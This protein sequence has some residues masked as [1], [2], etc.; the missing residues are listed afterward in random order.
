M[1]EILKNTSLFRDF[2][3]TV[4]GESI[5]HKMSVFKP[6]L[7]SLDNKKSQPTRCRLTIWR[8]L[9][10]QL[11]YTPKYSLVKDGVAR[12]CGTSFRARI[13]I[14]SNARKV[15]KFLQSVSLL[16]ND[17]TRLCVTCTGQ[18]EIHARLII[19]TCKSSLLIAFRQFLCVRLFCG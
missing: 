10:Y 17:S 14:P 15:K 6:F 9:L 3:R 13:S 5:M 11:S 16:P 19:F 1:T 2:L 18:G 7:S 12:Q 8:P 4:R